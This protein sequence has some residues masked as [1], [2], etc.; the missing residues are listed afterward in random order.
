MAESN[1]VV[2]FDIAINGRHTGRIEMRLYSH[3]TPKTC[4]NFRCL[5]TGEKSTPQKKLWF[6]GSIFHRV[7]PDF[8]LQGGD[9]TAG[10]GTG[11]ES[12]YGRKFPDE[13]FRMKHTGAGLLSMANSGPNSNGSQF[14]ITTQATPWLD[15]KHVVF[16]EVC[17]G[18]EIVKQI[19]FYG[20]NSGKV[21][22]K[23]E[24]TECGQ[25]A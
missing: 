25:L 10:N 2:Y 14:F 19:E 23:V 18:M 11:G 5:C 24:I 17:N 7:I 15:G 16:G 4:E 21:S 20:S 3:V 13:N 22:Q 8:M 12:I 9:F 6:Q 1:P